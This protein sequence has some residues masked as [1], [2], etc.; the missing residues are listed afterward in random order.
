MKRILIISIILLVCS[1]FVIAEYN[2]DL[3][4]HPLEQITQDTGGQ[5]SVTDLL[6]VRDGRVT[7]GPGTGGYV[8][9]P[10]I[11]DSSRNNIIAIKYPDTGE[12]ELTGIGFYEKNNQDAKALFIW[13]DKLDKYFWYTG[14]QSGDIKMTLTKDGKLGI[15]RQAPGAKLDV[16]GDVAINGQVIID[17]DGKWVGDATG[18]QG[19]QGLQGEQGLTGPAGAQGPQGLPGATG[20]A[21]AT[22]PQG[23]PGPAGE[24]GTGG[25][26]AWESIEITETQTTTSTVQISEDFETDFVKWKNIAGDDQDWKTNSGGTT[27]SGTGPAGAHGGTNY[28]YTEAS[29]SNVG[30]SNKVLEDCLL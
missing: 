27:S 8:D 28:A 13:N 10:L 11:I 1:V 29:G 25:D 19:P 7:I 6:K 15:G 23:P 26:S 2:S 4:W 20:P 24:G 22:G 9:F 12:I 5:K 3:A 17:S 21:G 16:G 30:Y 14:G 18:L